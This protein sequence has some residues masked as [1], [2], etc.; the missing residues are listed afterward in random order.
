[1]RELVHCMKEFKWH[2]VLKG[3]EISQNLDVRSRMIAQDAGLA[4]AATLRRL[5]T[6]ATEL[7]IAARK[8][9][10][11][12]QHGFVEHRVVEQIAQLIEQR[13]ALTL[14]RLAAG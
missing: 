12:P 14:K 6:L 5:K 10:A 1:M 8:L 13:C 9:Q 2:D 11:A 3:K 4:K 7:P